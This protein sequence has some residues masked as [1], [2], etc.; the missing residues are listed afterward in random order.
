MESLQIAGATQR[1]LVVDDL[2]INRMLLERILDIEGFQV[3]EA[4]DGPSARAISRAEQPDLILLDIMMP[5]E[6][7]LETCRR[8]KRDPL[9]AEIP[10]VFLSAL[11]DVETKVKGLMI[12][13]AD[14]VS[15]PFHPAEVLARVRVQLRGVQAGR[16]RITQLRNRLNEL[17]TAQKAMMV[18]AAD[19]P[20]A[21]FAVRYEP[22]E[23]A[24]A[25][26]YDAVRIAEGIHGYMVAD[27]SGHG[28]ATA[29]LTSALKALLR[30]H[31]GP[32]YSPEETLRAVNY[33]MGQIFGIEQYVTAC[34]VSLN[35]RS[36]V[37]SVLS[38]GHPPLIHV[39]EAG[40]AAVET[41]GDPLGI[42]GSVEFTLKE[43]PVAPGDRLY[44][45]TDGLIEAG[46]GGRK[47][48]LAR[49]LD[50]CWARRGLELDDAVVTILADVAPHERPVEDDRLLLAV[51]V[52][53]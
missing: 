1:I 26:F 12:G 24:G 17:G 31:A 16:M 39:S 51:E 13:G 37:A 32:Q 48:G 33:G 25:D 29:F 27:I 22:L 43:L 11:E 4:A 53:E 44:L 49:L 19:M 28:V 14:Y 6:D 47:A 7:G 8:L 35:R 2:A 15:K 21:A 38:A 52:R 41:E 46:D 5:G 34:Y 9:T 30:Q 20:E 23:E 18:R 10:V 3:L 42:F 40:A 45:Y 50:A 36:S